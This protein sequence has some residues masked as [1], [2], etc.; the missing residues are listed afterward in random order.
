MGSGLSREGSGQCQQPVP[1]PFSPRE[2]PVTGGV[3]QR[4]RGRE[5]SC[6]A[7]QGR[8][9]SVNFFLKGQDSRYFQC[10][11]QLLC[12]QSTKAARQEV[13]EGA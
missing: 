10:C 11:G 13:S 12:H 5:D 7:G 4:S 6:V 8:P 9:G 2:L 1:A 3:K